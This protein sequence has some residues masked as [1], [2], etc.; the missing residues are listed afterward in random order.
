MN[1]ENITS[2]RRQGSVLALQFQIPTDMAKKFYARAL[3]QVSQFAQIPGFRKGKAPAKLVEER[4]RE[5]I[6][7]TADDELIKSALHE[8]LEKEGVKHEDVISS[9]WIEKRSDFTLDAP[10]TV[11]ARVDVIPSFEVR[12]YKGVKLTKT[13]PEATDEMIE[14]E[15]K[16]LA[17]EHATLSPVDRPAKTDDVL[18]VDFE[19]AKPDGT[20]IPGAKMASMPIQIGSGRFI[21][22]FEDS[23]IG[24]T[25]GSE[26]TPVLT[27]PE[28]YAAEELR[29]Q[30]AHFTIKVQSVKERRVPEINEDFARDLTMPDLASVKAKIKEGIEESMAEDARMEMEADLL[31][32]L[33]AANPVPDL[34]QVLLDEEIER[35][36][37]GFQRRLREMRLTPEKFYE[38]AHTTPA[39]HEK[40]LIE[41][42]RATVH[43]SL[44]LRAV[45][46]AEDLSVTQDELSYAIASTAVRND[47]SP[48]VL[49]KRLAEEGRIG[50]V[51]FDLLKRKALHFV[52]EKAEIEGSQA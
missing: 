13:K 6:V 44:I 8:V 17:Q 27:F 9:P 23:L 5:H 16:R 14:S 28:N 18:V 25:A 30:K 40:D 45:A 10:I 34:P 33:R 42:A 1:L 39:D 38:I 29:G 51:K 22:G 46:I 32:K 48:E 43:S 24:A 35:R 4:Y 26:V 12:N 31:G 21:P 7:S 11:E 52:L 3:N 20:E 49:A 37:E 15:L 19:G 41:A 47:T 2:E 50:L 36:R